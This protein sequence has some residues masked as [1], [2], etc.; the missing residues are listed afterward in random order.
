MN[1]G[2]LFEVAVTVVVGALVTMAIFNEGLFTGAIS[3]GKN[4]IVLGFFAALAITAAS[5]ISG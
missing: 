4:A 1:G 5:Q 2:E 3:F